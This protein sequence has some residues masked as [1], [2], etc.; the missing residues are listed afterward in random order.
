VRQH[1]GAVL[2]EGGRPAEAERVYLEDLAR[3]PEN[4]WSLL[5]LAA[6]LRAQGKDG[7]AAEVER[8]RAAAWAASDVTPQA[9][10]Y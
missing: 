5:G 3:F 10:R 2:L 9:S 7:A 8:R 4:G 1:L 6:S